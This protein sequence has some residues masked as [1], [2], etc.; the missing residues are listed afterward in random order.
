VYRER[1]ERPKRAKTSWSS[2]IVLC[3]TWRQFFAIFAVKSCKVFNHKVHEGIAKK[4]LPR[5]MDE[6]RGDIQRVVIQLPEQLSR[7]ARQK[8]FELRSTDTRGRLSLHERATRAFPAAF[9]IK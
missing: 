5:P 7:G 1:P 3:E 8:A 4:C 9:P 6:R 2:L